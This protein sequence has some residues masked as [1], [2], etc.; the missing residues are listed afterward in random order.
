MARGTNLSYDAQSGDVMRGRAA[1]RGNSSNIKEGIRTQ[2]LLV[3][4]MA[5]GTAI[6]TIIFLVLIQQRLREQVTQDFSMDLERSVVTFQN[7]Q[8]ERFDA[9][10]RENALLAE[11]PTL[12]ALMTSGDR[13]TI[14][15]GALE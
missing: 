4:A 7:L 1:L 2:V 11:L 15:D 8:A 5:L 3:L 13:L 12:K 14:Q 10:N 9:L 6:V